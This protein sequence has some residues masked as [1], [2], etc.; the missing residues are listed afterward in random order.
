MS[1]VLTPL[2]ISAI[3]DR[4]DAFNLL[5]ELGAKPMLYEAVDYIIKRRSELRYYYTH[6]NIDIKNSYLYV[7]IDHTQNINQTY[8]Q[9][10]LTILN[11]ITTIHADELYF[12]DHVI[13]AVVKAG[14]NICMDDMNDIVIGRRIDVAKC[15]LD[16]GIIPDTNVLNISIYSTNVNM[17]ELMLH[18]GSEPN[19]ESLHILDER[20]DRR[21]KIYKQM[22]QLLI[23]AIEN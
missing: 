7:L 17:I 13:L 14:A 5:L 21:T 2:L 22:K 20:F 1:C 16:H 15:F 3:Q 4:L 6:L 19:E 10:N 11:I 12:S 9:Y 23:E 18:Y 8:G